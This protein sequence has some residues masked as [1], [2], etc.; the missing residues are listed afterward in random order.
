MTLPV[1]IRV[2]D[3]SAEASFVVGEVGGLLVTGA[4]HRRAE[5]QRIDLGI[6]HALRAAPVQHRP[7]A[8]AA[9]TCHP[10]SWRFWF[11][12]IPPARAGAR[13]LGCGAS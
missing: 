2:D 9:H 12:S 13:S 3:L 8:L 5:Q 6:A 11:N 7:C 1:R 10:C 4:G